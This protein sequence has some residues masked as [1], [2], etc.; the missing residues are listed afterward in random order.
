ML[1]ISSPVNA[2]RAVSLGLTNFFV[3]ICCPEIDL[4]GKVAEPS[5]QDSLGEWAYSHSVS[6]AL[7]VF[8]KWLA[9]L[10]IKSGD[11]WLHA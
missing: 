6:V 2:N 3:S 10:V 5:N 9:M 8:E 4:S 7:T 11:S 1:S